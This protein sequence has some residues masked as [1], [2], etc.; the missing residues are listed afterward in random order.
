MRISPI[1][2]RG[3]PASARAALPAAC[4]C[5]A[6]QGGDELLLRIGAVRTRPWLD[7]ASWRA[8]AWSALSL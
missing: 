5:S 3:K 7:E 4:N 2:P 1:C 8:G 6:P